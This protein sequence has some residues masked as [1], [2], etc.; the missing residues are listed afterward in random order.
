MYE[1]LLKQWFF[2]ISTGAGF[3][4]QQCVCFES[5]QLPSKPTSG[6]LRVVIECHAYEVPGVSKN[7]E[8]L[9][10]AMPEPS[11]IYEALG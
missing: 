8:N 4:H 9:G 3:F 11:T 7:M 10:V 5:S 6:N 1:T 2:S